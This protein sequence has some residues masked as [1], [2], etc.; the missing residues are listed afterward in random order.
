MSPAHRQASPRMKGAGAR[1][2]AKNNAQV[3]SSCRSNSDLKPKGSACA[4]GATQDDESEA[5]QWA[6]KGEFCFGMALVEST[7]KDNEGMEK[8]LSAIEEGLSGDWVSKQ[9]REWMLARVERMWEAIC[10]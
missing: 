4:E 2:R 5:M 1:R 9:D 7:A 3:A 8:Q 10:R 6:N